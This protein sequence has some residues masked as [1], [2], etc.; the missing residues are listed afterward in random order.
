MGILF[1][2]DE[3]SDEVEINSD[4]DSAPGSRNIGVV[5]PPVFTSNNGLVEDDGWDD[6]WGEDKVPPPDIT[7]LNVAG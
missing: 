3:D 2:S 7:N 1:S 4:N 6:D 5:P